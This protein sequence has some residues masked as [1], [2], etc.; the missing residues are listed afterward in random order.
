MYKHFFKRLIDIVLSFCGIIV[1]AI[2]MLFISLIIVIDDPGPVVF[3]QKRVGIKK[4]GELTYFQLWKFR[5]MKMSTPH[6]VPTHLLDNPE[7]YITRIGR[8]LRK[9][10]ADELL[11]IFHIFSGKM[12]I[13]GPRPALWNQY[14]LIAERDKYGAN[15]V[16][17]GL[18]GWAQ[19]NG[20]DE[21]EIEEKARLDGEYV[22]HLTFR[23][24]WT[25]FW[26]TVGN[27]LKSKGVIEGG[28]GV[29]AKQMEKRENEVREAALTDEVRQ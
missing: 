26:M 28:T 19:V 24:D 14:D 21:I 7:Q 29:M 17:P 11:Q 3:K 16:T 10:S 22:S 12:S 1:L 2:P 27:V 23:M 4:N 6:D 5:S 20:R 9:T 18:T 15:D 8:V 13:I 25:C